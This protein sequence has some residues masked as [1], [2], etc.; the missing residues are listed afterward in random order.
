MKHYFWK[1]TPEGPV[2]CSA[3]EWENRDPMDLLERTVARCIVGGV[4]IS[5][6]FTGINVQKEKDGPPLLYQTHIFGSRPRR[7]EGYATREEAL[8][9]HGRWVEHFRAQSR[10]DEQ[11]Q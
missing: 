6:V 3:E 8:K 1:L 9:G 10:G 4:M 11:P 5:T 7:E 2:P